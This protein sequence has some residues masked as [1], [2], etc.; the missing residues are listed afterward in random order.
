MVGYS[1]GMEPDLEALTQAAAAGDRR[2][3]EGLLEHHLPALRAYVRLRAGA[4]VRN[5]EASSDLVQSVCREVLERADNFRYPSDAAFRR[6]LFTT[7]LRKI[8]DRRK[9]HLA[10]K[11]DVGRDLPIASEGAELAV[12]QAY[13]KLT[14]PSQNAVVKEELERIEA[15]MDQLSEE[16]RE[17]VSLSHVVGL[18]RAQIAEQ[19]GKSEGSVRML[20]HRS[21]ARL[22]VL[23]R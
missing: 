13:G 8:M 15:A 5:R 14:T 16:Q 1:G 23:L 2:A 12:L 22:A 7:A 17:V 21:M 10:E 20:L 4:L 18:S 19:V 3:L 11:R 9:F 6:W